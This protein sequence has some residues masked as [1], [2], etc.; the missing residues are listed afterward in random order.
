VYVGS[1]KHGSRGGDTIAG[2][3]RHDMSEVGTPV[4]AVAHAA[5]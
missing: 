3:M 4:A 2:H 1:S 5:T